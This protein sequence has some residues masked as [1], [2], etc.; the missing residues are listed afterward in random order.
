MIRKIAVLVL[1][2]LTT[3]IFADVKTYQKYEDAIKDAQKDNK[4]IAMTIVSTNCPWCH[5]LL[6]ETIKDKKVEAMLNKDFVYV[7][8]NKD[9]SPIPNGLSARMVPTT[10]FLD[11]NG[12]KLT[13][14][15]IGYWDAENF[16]SYLMDAI[17]KA[18]KL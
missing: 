10:F 8:I 17:K 2:F 16:E 15:A 7:V 11:K 3:S 1:L 9:V 12:Q 5:K 14:P 6:R 18:K 4:L 13:Q